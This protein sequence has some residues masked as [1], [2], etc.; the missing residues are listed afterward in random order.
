MLS[1]CDS[2]LKVKKQDSAALQQCSFVNALQRLKTDHVKTQET[3]QLVARQDD[4]CC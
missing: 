4:R 1:A 2:G 3:I